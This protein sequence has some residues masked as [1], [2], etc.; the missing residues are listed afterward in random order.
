[1]N[2]KKLAKSQTLQSW[3]RISFGN[4]GKFVNQITI[5]LVSAIYSHSAR[6]TPL[7]LLNN[8]ST[9][10]QTNEAG[11]YRGNSK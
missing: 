1:M 11:Q 8:T 2:T 9:A 3:I 6:N 10:Q 5:N 7:S 4:C